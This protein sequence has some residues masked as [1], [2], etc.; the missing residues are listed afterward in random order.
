MAGV[1]ALL[2]PLRLRRGPGISRGRAAGGA[3]PDRRRRVRRGGAA[4]GAGD[5]P[6]PRAPQ[7][8]DAGFRPS[9]RAQGDAR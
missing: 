8:P 7:G 3:G 4:R 1:R 5:A 6:G 9:G 2:R